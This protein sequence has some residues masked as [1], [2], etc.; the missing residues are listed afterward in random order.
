MFRYCED[1]YK[2][3]FGLSTINITIFHQFSPKKFCIPQPDAA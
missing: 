2:F 1:K 3:M